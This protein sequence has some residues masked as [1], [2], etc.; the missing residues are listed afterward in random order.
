M[1]LLCGIAAACNFAAQ[2]AVKGADAFIFGMGGVGF[3]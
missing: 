3:K 2:P 1:T